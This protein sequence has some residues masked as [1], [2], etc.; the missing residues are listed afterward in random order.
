M[1]GFARLRLAGLASSEGDKGALVQV[2]SAG[3]GMINFNLDLRRIWSSDG[4]PLI[5]L[6]SYVDTFDGVPPTGTALA[7]GSY[8]QAIGSVG[9]R[10]GDGYVSLVGTY[11][12][13][14]HLKSDY[15]IGPSVNWPLVIRNGLSVVLE[16][17]AQRTRTTTAGFAGVRMLFSRGGLS[18]S[19]LA[20]RSIEDDRAA[21]GGAVSRAT[22]SLNAQYSAET[23]GGS[24]LTGEFGTDRS[25]RSSSVHA[26]GT[27]TSPVGNARLDLVHNFE[28]A[29]S[30]QYD[31]GFQSGLALSPGSVTLG[32]RQTDQSAI[33]VSVDGD[34]AGAGFRVLVDDMPRG[35][36]RVGERLPLFVPAY[37]TYHVRLLPID[38]AAV[39]FDSGSR[40]VTL[41]PGNVQS[42]EWKAESYFTLVAQ[43]VSA[44]GAPIADAL[45]QTRRN[46]AET[47]EHGYFQIDLRHGEPV[48]IARDGGGTCTVRLPE[49]VVRQ[50]FAS[51]GKVS[52]E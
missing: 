7:S 8:T 37:R 48:R 25:I 20:G 30:T 51:V 29:R 9:L 23:D 47:D 52:C 1:T 38:A 32:A 5:P 24:L 3:Q 13:D 50:D 19:S 36:V 39:E 35:E 17:S 49:L 44:S 11:R 27:M 31:L 34:A 18:M 14:R 45:V 26:G 21:P 40:E 10:L 42:L 16:A 15:S 6:P 2:A 28:G 33:V 22:A 43:A 41:Y 4:Q 46:V 12:K